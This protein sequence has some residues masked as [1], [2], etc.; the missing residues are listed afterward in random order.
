MKRLLLIIPLLL[1]ASCGNPY[2]ETDKA[3]QCGQW[4]C[5]R[6]YNNDF[7]GF[8]HITSAGML[9]F[10]INCI[11]TISPENQLEMDIGINANRFISWCDAE[12][13]KRNPF[14][15]MYKEC[16]NTDIK[17]AMDCI[18]KV[19]AMEVNVEQVKHPGA[20]CGNGGTLCFQIQDE[21]WKCDPELLCITN[22]SIS[23]PPIYRMANE[24]NH[25]TVIDSSSCPGYWKIEGDRQICYDENKNKLF[26][27]QASSFLMTDYCSSHP[28]DM[29]KCEC[30][31]EIITAIN[32]KYPYKNLKIWVRDNP[33]NGAILD[34]SPSYSL[35]KTESIKVDDII[36]IKGECTHAVPK[37]NQ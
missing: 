6:D 22:M 34:V 26:D 27:V 1:L 9:Q 32:G 37:V 21:K 31:N 3:K 29:E 28:E 4:L 5:V 16:Q 7:D 8:S 11:N 12:W 15:K 20:S 18:D 13:E 17:I 25:S 36:D 33:M 35:I 10:H 23:L 24:T 30:D 19:V 2:F 14:E